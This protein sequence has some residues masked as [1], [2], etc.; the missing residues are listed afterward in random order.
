MVGGG[1]G[2]TNQR[3]WEEGGR[4]TRKGSR[5]SP[6]M[7]A[8]SSWG[9]MHS[10]YGRG[11]S[12]DKLDKAELHLHLEG[13][14]EAETLLAI[15]PSLSREEIEANLTCA[16]FA[17]FMRG[18]VWVT[19]LLQ[20]PEHYALATRHL[21]ERLAAEGVPY[22]EITLSAGGEWWTGRDLARVDEALREITC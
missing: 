11:T 16:S 8:S 19:K 9:S 15:D 14:I 18:Y 2:E 4:R 10:Y 13:S 17:E 22:A 6:P 21:L 12:G 20:T 3:A 1:Q 7:I 5:G